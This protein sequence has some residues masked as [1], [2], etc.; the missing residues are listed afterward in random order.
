M[1]LTYQP[2]TLL[3]YLYSLPLPKHPKLAAGQVLLQV[4]VKSRVSPRSAKWVTGVPGP[5]D[6]SKVHEY[7]AQKLKHHCCEQLGFPANS[8]HQSEAMGEWVGGCGQQSQQHTDPTQLWKPLTASRKN[9]PS[10]FQAGWVW[11]KSPAS[12]WNQTLTGQ[13][14]G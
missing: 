14:L 8:S 3:L 2:V 12:P 7:A 4:N 10:I 5:K 6:H 11:A 13:L 9:S 1:Y